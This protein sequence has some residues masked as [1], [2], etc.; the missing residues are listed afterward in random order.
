[1]HNKAFLISMTASAKGTK[2]VCV[3]ENERER[4]RESSSCMAQSS[5]FCALLDCLIDK[6]LILLY[7][8]AVYGRHIKRFSD[9]S[10]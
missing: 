10:E 6:F 5:K 9:Y 4:V 8:Y 7:S 1:M 3:R 2:S